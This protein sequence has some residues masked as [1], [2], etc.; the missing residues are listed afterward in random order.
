MFYSFDYT[1]ESGEV[2][3]QLPVLKLALLYNSPPYFLP[4]YISLLISITYFYYLSPTE[5]RCLQWRLW[6]IVV[7]LLPPTS[8]IYR[9]SRATFMIKSLGQFL[10]TAKLTKALYLTPNK[11][12]RGPLLN[13]L[14]IAPRGLF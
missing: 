12:L 7:S 5:W 11:I 14:S 8:C 9:D 3:N 2:C 4:S 13:P 10:H 6:I 1:V